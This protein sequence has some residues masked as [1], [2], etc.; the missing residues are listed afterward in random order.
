[1]IPEMVRAPL[2]QVTLFLK[3]LNLG[4]A[5]HFLALAPDP[6]PLASVERALAAL[7]DLKALD[8]QEN[9]TSLG[10]Q[11][12]KLPVEP[13][14]GFALLASCLFG[15]AEPLSVLAAL[16]AAPSLYNDDRRRG[17]DLAARGGDTT[18]QSLLSDHYDM[19]ITFYRLRDIPIDQAVYVCMREN[20]NFKVFQ[21]VN[22]AAEQTSG[23]LSR[24]GFGPDPVSCKDWLCQIGTRSE[25]QEH[26]AKWATLIFL[27]GMGLE[28]FAVRKSLS[29]KVWVG[30]GKT[31][32]VALSVGIPEVPPQDP[33]RPFF[34]FAELQES[35][36]SSSCRGVSAAGA[37][38]TILGAARELRYD[39]GRGCL[40][41]DGWAPVKLSHESAVRLGAARSALRICLLT[42]A[43]DPATRESCHQIPLFAQLITEMCGYG[44]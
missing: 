6:P 1:L 18:A 23:I 25:T 14:M 12:A 30:Q 3:S 5:A 29:R 32:Q 13:R 33:M 27:L 11:L 21:Q 36:W 35:E 10:V 40:L 17:K 39:H 15:L 44:L 37:I 8:R 26:Q 43:K 20:L 19:L 4:G 7:M 38:A 9:I 42:I 22:D 28:H 16:S 24:M 2:H 34:L 31:S 41:L